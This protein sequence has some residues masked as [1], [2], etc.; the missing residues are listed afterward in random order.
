MSSIDPGSGMS[1]GCSCVSDFLDCTCFKISFCSTNGN[2]R[3]GGK[4]TFEKQQFLAR[5]RVH[6]SRPLTLLSIIAM[7]LELDEISCE[8]FDDYRSVGS[9]G[10]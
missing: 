7:S 10:M 4:Y 9:S 2:M 5:S 1:V 3:T 8:G 6:E